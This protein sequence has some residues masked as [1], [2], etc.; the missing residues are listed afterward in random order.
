MAA[1]IATRRLTAATTRIEVRRLRDSEDD[2]DRGDLYDED[3]RRAPGLR[4]VD[5]E[6]ISEEDGDQDTAIAI[7]FDDRFERREPEGVW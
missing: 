5:R 3:D 6:H 7:E 4:Q 2:R 1:A